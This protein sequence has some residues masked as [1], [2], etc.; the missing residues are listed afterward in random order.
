MKVLILGG[1]QFIGKHV[2]HAFLQAGHQITHANRGKTAPD[3][4]PGVPQIK[5]DRSQEDSEALIPLRQDWDIVVDLSAYFPRQVE[6]VINNLR[7]HIGRYV[8]CSTIS[9]Y[10]ESLGSLNPRRSSVW[11]SENSDLLECTKEQASNS[12]MTT[13]GNRKAG[14]EQVLRNSTLPEYSIIRPSI[15]YGSH[16]HTDRFAYWI[17]RACGNSPYLLPENGMTITQ[18]TYAP[19]LGNAF[20]LASTLSRAVGNAYNIAD[21]EPLSLRDS[22]LEMGS[23]KLAIDISAETLDKLGV[24]PWVDLPLWIPSTHFLV[25]TFKSRSELGF[26]STPVGTALTEARR[27]FQNEGRTPRAGL[28]F[29]AEA[30]LIEALPYRS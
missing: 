18:K 11:M 29:D 5:F 16:D 12:E 8:F 20:L 26:K 3:G 22:I 1:T 14:C 6:Y 24:R 4:L 21:E 9:V 15:V 30:K 2:T 28:S 13:Y 7:D 25:D 10:K 17:S 19:D 27:S 23:L